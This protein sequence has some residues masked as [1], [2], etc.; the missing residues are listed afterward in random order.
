MSR[1]YPICQHNIDSR[2]NGARLRSCQGLFGNAFL[3][4]MR[5]AD[6]LS[7]CSHAAGHFTQELS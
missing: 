6:R 4:V 7:I 5:Y 1:E 3:S 2:R